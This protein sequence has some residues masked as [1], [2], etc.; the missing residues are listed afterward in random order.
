[1]G[2]M[3]VGLVLR[4]EIEALVSLSSDLSGLAPVSLLIG[5]R[6]FSFLKSKNKDDEESGVLGDTSLVLRL[7]GVDRGASSEDSEIFPENYL[8]L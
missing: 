7:R 8:N 1:M 6:N 3:R 2:E 5:N 4:L